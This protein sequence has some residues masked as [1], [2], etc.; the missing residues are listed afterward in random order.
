VGPQMQSKV[1]VGSHFLVAGVQLDPI[2]E[3][4]HV[5]KQKR[6][7]IS[8]QRPRVSAVGMQSAANW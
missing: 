4:F 7:T 1:D 6:Y 3:A 8:P 2:A 5:L